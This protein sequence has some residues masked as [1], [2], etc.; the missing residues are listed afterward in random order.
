MISRIDIEDMTDAQ[1]EALKP[2]PFCGGK[3]E[4]IHIGNGPNEGGSCVSCSNCLASSNL[5]FGFKENFRNNWNRRADLA[6]PSQAGD[7]RVARLESIV[8]RFIALPSGAWHPERC[9]ADEA[10]LMG[11]ARAALAAMDTPKGGGDE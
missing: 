5:E 10:E 3:A 6:H 8:R 9:A 1:D 7:E 11:D 4:V 2:C